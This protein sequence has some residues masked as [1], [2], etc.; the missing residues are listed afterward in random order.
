LS[1]KV[2]AAINGMKNRG[3]DARLYKHQ[4]KVWV[5]IDQCMLASFEEIEELVDGVHSFDELAELFKRRHTQ[6]LGGL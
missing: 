5:E 1:V 4:G 6:E 2:V 3:H